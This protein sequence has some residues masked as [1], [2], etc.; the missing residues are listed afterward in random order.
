VSSI[1]LLA[2]G[3][4]WASIPTQASAFPRRLVNDPTPSG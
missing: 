1:G 2:A 4:A 3:L